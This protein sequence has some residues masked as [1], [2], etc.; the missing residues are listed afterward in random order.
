MLDDTL[1]CDICNCSLL[2][3]VSLSDV[4][5]LLNDAQSK[6]HDDGAFSPTNQKNQ[7]FFLYWHH[8]SASQ[9]DPWPKFQKYKVSAKYFLWF[10]FITQHLIWVPK[11]Y[12]L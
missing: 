5:S 7:I 10:G 4:V 12:K 1:K 11:K 8:L 3:V 2:D 6:W 9:S